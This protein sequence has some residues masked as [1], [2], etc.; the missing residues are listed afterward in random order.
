MEALVFHRHTL[1]WVV[2]GGVRDGRIFGVGF[3]HIVGDVWSFM[4]GG[5]VSNQFQNAIDLILWLRLGG[6]GFNLGGESLR[7]LDGGRCG[8]LDGGSGCQK[9][10]EGKGFHIKFFKNHRKVHSF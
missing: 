10:G 3:G 6:P 5:L 1:E 2:M 4:M 8:H 7:G 9:G